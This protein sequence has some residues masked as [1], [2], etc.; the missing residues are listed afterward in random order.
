MIPTIEAI[1]EGLIDGTITKR[2]AVTWLHQHAEDAGRCL[3]DDFAAM[4]LQGLLAST[5]TLQ[6]TF[7]KYSQ[8][9]YA[10]AD[11]MLKERSAQ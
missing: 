9:A 6:P 11:A 10:H 7:E 4:A 1:V 3:R 5:G 8:C 2:Q